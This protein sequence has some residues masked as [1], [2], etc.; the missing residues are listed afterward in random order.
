VVVVRNTKDRAG[1]VL[2]FGAVPD[3]L[4]RIVVI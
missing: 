1:A 3:K 4:S 2:A